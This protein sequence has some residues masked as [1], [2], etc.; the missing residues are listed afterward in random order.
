MLLM[1]VVMGS[2][3]VLS[4]LKLI[5]SPSSRNEWKP[6]NARELIKSDE[7]KVENISVITFKRSGSAGQLILREFDVH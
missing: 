6:V 3:A 5:F 1:E 4:S 7:V 2:V